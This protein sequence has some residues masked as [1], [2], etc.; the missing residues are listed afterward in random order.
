VLYYVWVELD[1]IGTT[2]SSKLTFTARAYQDSHSQITL[3]PE[4]LS[5][6]A[7]GNKSGIPETPPTSIDHMEVTCPTAASNQPSTGKY[8]EMSEQ[9]DLY[10]SPQQA[11][12]QEDQVSHDLETK[13]YSLIGWK[14]LCCSTG[15]A[16]KAKRKQYKSERQQKQQRRNAFHH[17]NQD[18]IIQQ[19]SFEIQDLVTR[20][21]D[22]ERGHKLEIEAKIQQR[23]LRIRIQSQKIKDDGNIIASLKLEKEEMAAELESRD[24]MQAILLVDL[25][26]LCQVYDEEIQVLKATIDRQG[27]CTSSP[28][29][30]LLC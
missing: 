5:S 18:R 16:A 2:P 6:P 23:D 14:Q 21:S 26:E 19:K 24:Q 15:E 7:S 9:Q 17:R 22:L 11:L 4:K 25:R 30:I 12:S 10:N 3:R 27:K 28:T 20:I 8:Q 29:L 1:I 13:G